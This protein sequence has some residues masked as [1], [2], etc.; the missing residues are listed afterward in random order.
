MTPPLQR[1]PSDIRINLILQKLESLC[2]I[3]VAESMGLSSFKFSWLAP[4]D[5]RVL[6]SRSSKVI[7]FGTNQKCVCD[8]LLVINN[9]LGPILLLSEDIAGFLLRRATPP[10]FH[11]NFGGVALGLDC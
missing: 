3:V 11:L 9:N 2:N 5:A 7:D 4:K 1:T 10:L 6:P 8:F